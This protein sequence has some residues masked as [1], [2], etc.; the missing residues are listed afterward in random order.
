MRKTQKKI[1]GLLGL[2]LVAV[3]TIFAAFMPN[4][5]ASAIEAVGTSDSL[6]IR[7]L[8]EVPSISILNPQSDSL[9]SSLNDSIMVN[10]VNLKEFTVTVYYVDSEGVEHETESIPVETPDETGV[11]EF[12]FREMGGEYGYGKYIVRVTGD[13]LD[14]SDVQDAVWFEYVAIV[15]DATVD[16][17]NG[18]VSVDL[19]YDAD[20]EGL[21]DDEKAGQIVINIYD[22]N[23]NPV[24]GISPIIINAPTKHID[25]SFDEYGL[26]SGNYKITVTPYSVSGKELY[27]TLSLYVKYDEILVPDT[28][29]L[30]KGLNISQN[31]YLITGVGIFLVVGIGGI[32]FINRRSKSNS[33]R[34]K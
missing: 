23:G 21:S 1:L 32:I 22:E 27:R 8:D 4:P 30:F 33:R 28:G 5:S 17:D 34:R 2:V 26:P 13:G 6:E 29:G 10:Y 11:Q 19:A 31:D 3:M 7:V 25:I 16:E 9:T 15:A 24:P 18:T 12:S 14:G 20:D